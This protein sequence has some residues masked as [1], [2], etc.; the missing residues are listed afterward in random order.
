VVACRALQCHVSSSSL[1]N[2]CM[3][4]LG[5][6]VTHIC[7]TKANI[8]CGNGWGR[9]CLNLADLVQIDY[10]VVAT[11]WW[12]RHPLHETRG[13]AE[14]NMGAC[15]LDAHLLSSTMVHGLHPAAPSCESV[16]YDSTTPTGHSVCFCLHVPLVMFTDLAVA[17]QACCVR[18]FCGL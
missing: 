2:R 4:L 10:D 16:C 5:W 15:L 14:S 13:L 3:G 8:D 11:S 18:G 9:C 7:R 1:G 6:L 17:L 12:A